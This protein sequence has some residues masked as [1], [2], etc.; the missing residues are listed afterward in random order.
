MSTPTP[1]SRR[2]AT[3]IMAAP[4]ANGVLSIPASATQK[5]TAAG[6][7][8]PFT[9]AATPRLKVIIR[10]LPPGLTLAE[11][12]VGLGDE[13]KVS[14]GKVDWFVYKEG[15]VS[16]DPTKPSRPSRAYLH[17]TKSEYLSTLSEHVRT[18][19]FNDV[20]GSTRDSALL[21]PPSVEFAPYGRVPNGRARKDLRQGTIDQDQEFIDFL[22]SLTN[23]ITKSAPVDQGGDAFGKNKEKITIT[24]LIQFLKD[25][26]ANKGKDVAAAPKGVKHTR[27]D[28]KENKAGISLDKKPTKTESFTVSSPDKR[29][30]QAIKVEKAAR[31][32]VRVISKASSNS[33]S[34]ASSPVNASAAPTA[35]AKNS[36]PVAEKKRERGSAS[37]AAKILQRDLGISANQNGRGGRRAGTGSAARPV[38][39]TLSPIAS[40]PD[41]SQ[42]QSSKDPASSILPNPADKDPDPSPAPTS[43]TAI[44]AKPPNNNQPPRGPAASRPSTKSNLQS[45]LKLTQSNSANVTGKTTTLS[46][47]ATQAFLKHA[48]PSQ[49]ITEPLLEEA[50]AGFGAVKRVEIDKKKGFAYVDFVEPQA[51]QDAINA[52]PIKVA[53][54]QVVVLE[55]KVGPSLQARNARG[56]SSMMGNRGG[57]LPVGPRGGRGGSTRRG[58]LGRGGSN[59]SNPNISKA[60]QIVASSASPKSTTFP[61]APAPGTGTFGSA[62]SISGP[63]TLPTPAHTMAANNDPLY[64]PVS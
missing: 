19:T 1:S 20:R 23:P 15:K 8:R 16:K 4:R 6:S 35:V 45:E 34:P 61:A 38:A 50:F 54:G 37:A 64:P 5:R 41:G 40:K 13:W 24:P 17:L 44:I 25:K 60:S 62:E 18:A 2:S 43:A 42:A 28:S 26:K 3:K 52:S 49:G 32:V 59:A 31:D 46:T 22:E 58:G 30:A 53:Q 9:K 57:G 29:S 10:R 27:Q 33:K 48:N 12:E 14:G 55:R 47:N 7:V 36:A 51:L 63:A 11:F 39:N 21:G 56:G